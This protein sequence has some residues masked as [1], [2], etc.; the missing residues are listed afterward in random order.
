MDKHTQNKIP[1]KFSSKLSK[2]VQI[3]KEVCQGSHLSPTLFSIYLD[4]ITKWL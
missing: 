2:L 1:T 4:K 3:N